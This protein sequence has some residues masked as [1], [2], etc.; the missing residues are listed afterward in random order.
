MAGGCVA[1]KE[2]SSA[3]CGVR[4][5]EWATG[6]GALVDGGWIDGDATPL[7]LGGFSGAGRRVAQQKVE[8]KNKATK[9]TVM[10]RPMIAASLSR[11]RM[12]PSRLKMKPSGVATM[13]VNPP[14]VEMGEPQPGLHSHMAASATRGASERQRPIRPKPAFWFDSGSAWM[15]GGASIFRCSELDLDGFAGRL[16]R[17]EVELD[18]DG[19]FLAN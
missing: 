7:G 15:L 16:Q 11:L 19:D 5:A 17:L 18:V 2:V 6:V 14:R 1:G 3:E 12:K 13:I 10:A 8:N 4:S 9:P